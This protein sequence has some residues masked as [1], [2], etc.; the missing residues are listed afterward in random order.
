MKKQRRLWDLTGFYLVLAA[1]LAALFLAWLP[2]ALAQGPAPG[3]P[4]PPSERPEPPP[5]RPQKPVQPVEPGIEPEGRTAADEDEDDE[6][7]VF[8]CAGVHGFVAN[9][10]YRGEAQVPVVLGGES[11][12][13][14]KTADDNGYYAFDCLGSGVGLLNV[15][16]PGW[17][18]PMTTDIAIPLDSQTSF[19][20][21]LGLY[22]GENFP[23]LPV[24]PTLS[25]SPDRARPGDVLTY[26]LQVTNPAGRTG[27]MMTGVL[28]T[29]LL[30]EGLSPIGAVSDRGQVTWWGNLVTIRPGDL[31]PGQAVTVQITARVLPDAPLAL[32]N[33]A[34]LIYADHV[35]VQTPDVTVA[36]LAAGF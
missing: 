10:G 30:P 18:K 22:S 5:G 6:P 15:A 33:R 14:L 7:L 2:V 27:G 23:E 8:I 36:V 34:S 13:T 3:R 21:N 1:L 4:K 35:A 16:A 9:W 29:D 24:A 31:A 12:Q 19:E 20:V 11:W 17:L 25:A 26:T 28:L 32:A